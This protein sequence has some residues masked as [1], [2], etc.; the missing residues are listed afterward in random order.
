MVAIIVD[1]DRVGVAGL[2]QRADDLPNCVRSQDRL[3][4]PGDAMD[5]ETPACRVHPVLPLRGPGDPI[6][7]SLFVIGDGLVVY[8]RGVGLLKPGADVRRLRV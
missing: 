2:L 3:S 8:V 1:A 6:P 4:C 7:C 5:P